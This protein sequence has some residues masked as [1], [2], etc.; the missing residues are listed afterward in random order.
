MKY[1]RI[2]AN[3][4]VMYLATQS[5]RDIDIRQ[6]YDIAT[7]T[8]APDPKTADRKILEACSDLKVQGCDPVLLHDVPALRGALCSLAW[9]CPKLS[10]AGREKL[11]F[12]SCPT[13]LQPNG[14]ESC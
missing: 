14:S 9:P 7:F 4:E 3:G 1:L 13:L 6:A 5:C 8:S 10:L 11:T 12:P 2:A